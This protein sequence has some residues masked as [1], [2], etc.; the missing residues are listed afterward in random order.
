MFF[1][2]KK[3]TPPIDYDRENEEPVLRCS[4]CTGEKT[5][6]FQNIKTGRFREY[7]LIRDEDE[8]REFCSRCGVED[9]KKIY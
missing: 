4:I 5:A 7:M 3:E 8:I 1:K 6:G 9:V 2:R